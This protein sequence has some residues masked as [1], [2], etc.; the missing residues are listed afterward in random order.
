MALVSFEHAY[1]SEE[2]PCFID[3]GFGVPSTTFCLVY[4]AMTILHEAAG[5]FSSTWAG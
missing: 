1:M 2:A 5:S 3:I 4:W